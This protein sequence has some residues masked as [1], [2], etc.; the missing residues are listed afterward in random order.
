[1]ALWFQKYGAQSGT[2]LEG[3]GNFCKGLV[4]DISRLMAAFAPYLGAYPS[5]T[6]LSADPCLEPI[7]GSSHILQK[8]LLS[9]PGRSFRVGLMMAQTPRRASRLAESNSSLSL[10]VYPLKLSLNRTCRTWRDRCGSLS[11]LKPSIPKAPILCTPP[12]NRR[13]CACSRTGAWPRLLSCGVAGAWRGNAR[14]SQPRRV[15]QPAWDIAE[16]LR[17]G[18]WARTKAHKMRLIKLA[19]RQ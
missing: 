18:G 4:E 17:G 8:H 1:M 19:S 11:P 6:P 12:T 14:P 2:T 9:R 3:P 10:D 16:G 7:F 15:G 13:P 5:S